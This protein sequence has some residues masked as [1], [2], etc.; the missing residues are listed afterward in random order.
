MSRIY[1][2][3]VCRITNEKNV[4]T[5]GDCVADLDGP[6]ILT[7]TIPELNQL[8]TRGAE[9]SY[10]NIDRIQLDRLTLHYSIVLSKSCNLCYL[11]LA[12][13]EFSDSNTQAFFN[14]VQ[15]V[16]VND[17]RLFIRLST[18]KEYELQSEIQHRL[19]A[20]VMEQNQKSN[21]PAARIN[22]LQQQVAEVKTVMSDNVV[23]IL[24]R[25]ERLEN[26]DSRAE[27]LNQ[28]SQSFKTTARRVQRNMCLKNL[29]WTIILTVFV[30]L[31]V[32][33]IIIL[34][35]NGAGVFN[36]KKD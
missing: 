7:P 33:L 12:E 17:Q 10:S 32:V 36:H 24:E 21:V 27:A 3:A 13:N 35:L 22:E 23:R 14:A 6:N 19:F 18:A 25:G 26:I 34:I 16:I 5:L 15:T 31:I 8:I 1:A 9:L 11:V 29:K 2:A 20:L 30:V 4:V 28:S